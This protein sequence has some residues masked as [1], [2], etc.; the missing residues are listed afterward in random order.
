MT[1]EE[2]ISDAAFYLWPAIECLDLL[3]DS[4]PQERHTRKRRAARALRRLIKLASRS[5]R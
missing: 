5:G 3:P 1:R 2:K 4:T